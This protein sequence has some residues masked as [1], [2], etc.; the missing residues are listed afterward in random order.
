MRGLLRGGGRFLF[1]LCLL[2]LGRLLIALALLGFGSRGGGLR[3]LRGLL[4]GGGRFL[5]RLC[6][7]GLG[8][9]LGR[10]LGLGLRP[11]FD[12]FR[13]ALLYHLCAQKL[14]GR[15]LAVDVGDFQG[16][17]LLSVRAFLLYDGSSDVGVRVFHRF[18]GI[19]GHHIL[20][21][22]AVAHPFHYQHGLCALVL[23]RNQVIGSYCDAQRIQ[24]GSCGLVPVF[25]A[26][27]LP[28][29]YDL[30]GP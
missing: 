17:L 9:L 26:V 8:R 28:E 13:L 7:L 10:G 4:R 16:L 29:G 15:R 22:G 2:G 14:A 21:F 18:D 12:H 27:V 25:Y 19:G 11:H 6:L 30:Y 3:L 1:R 23:H 24:Y 20:R 5:F